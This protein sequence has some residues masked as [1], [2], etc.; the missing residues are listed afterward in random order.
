MYPLNGP[1]KNIYINPCFSICSFLSFSDSVVAI[2]I[3]LSFPYP[4]FYSL[5]LDFISFPTSASSSSSL[6]SPLCSDSPNEI[7]LACLVLYFPLSQFCE[8]KSNRGFSIKKQQTENTLY[9]DPT[10]RQPN[11]PKPIYNRRQSTNLF[12]HFLFFSF[13]RTIK[14]IWISNTDCHIEP[15]AVLHHRYRCFGSLSWRAMLSI[16]EKYPSAVHY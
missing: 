6:A 1:T 11:Q 8:L 16:K 14:T 15:V 12:S 7:N 13:S 2:K 4:I 3:L 9:K 5:F 10:C